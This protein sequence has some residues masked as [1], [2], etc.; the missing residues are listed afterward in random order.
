MTDQS[1]AVK[2]VRLLR[3][4]DLRE[5]PLGRIQ[6]A[7]EGCRYC[8]DEILDLFKIETEII[9]VLG[10]EYETSEHFKETC[11]Y[12]AHRLESP[13]KK[14]RPDQTE[15]E[16]IRD[17]EI[18]RHAESLHRQGNDLPESLR[19]TAQKFFVSDS[20]ARDARK[21]FLDGIQ[22]INDHPELKEYFL[23]CIRQTKEY[24]IHKND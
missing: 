14:G 11:V 22:L 13:M 6:C 23:D 9:D 8:H 20:K 19:L 18:G 21:D 2:L 4:L 17:F 3:H 24:L 15:R 10:G 16:M 12:I 5:H 1:K 7:H